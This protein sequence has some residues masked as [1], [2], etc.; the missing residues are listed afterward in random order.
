MWA[1]PWMRK[2]PERGFK[3]LIWDRSL[4]LCFPLASH[5]VLFLTPDRTRGP[6]QS[7]GQGGF[8]SEGYRMV[9]RT[10]YGLAPPPFVTPGVLLR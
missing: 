4:G 8:Q 2:V 9:T 1:P 10:Y 3:S 7:V 5:L 6:P